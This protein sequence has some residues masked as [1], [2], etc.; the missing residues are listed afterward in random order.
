MYLISDNIFLVFLS[1]VFL[2]A[3]GFGFFT[4]IFDFISKD[5]DEQEEDTAD[6]EDKGDNDGR[7]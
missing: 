7:L 3:S 2:G 1:A 4:L 5:L 6:Q